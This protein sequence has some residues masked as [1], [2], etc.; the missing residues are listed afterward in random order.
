MS[1]W[2]SGYSPRGE[3]D[4]DSVAPTQDIVGTGPLWHALGIVSKVVCVP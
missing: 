3:H 1:Q 4:S 2:N